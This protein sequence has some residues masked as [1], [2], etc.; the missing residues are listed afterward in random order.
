MQGRGVRQG[1]EGDKWKGEDEKWE[2]LAKTKEKLKRKIGKTEGEMDRLRD[3][4]TP[5]KTC[6][7]FISQG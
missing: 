7:F 3:K 2:F 1:D 4:E 5:W 6:G